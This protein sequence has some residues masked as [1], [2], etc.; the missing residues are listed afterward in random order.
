MSTSRHLL[1]QSFFNGSGYVYL[2]II[3]LISYPWFIRFSGASLFG[4]YLTIS[5]LIS[6][7]ITLDYG[8]SK[9][10][11]FH[12]ASLKPN[13]NVW[14]NRVSAGLSLSMIA[15]L[16][17]ASLYFLLTSNYIF[18]LNSFRSYA[19]E[20]TWLVL[21]PALI[22]FVYLQN[23]TLLSLFQSQQ[24]FAAYNLVLC[25][26]GT[27]NTILSVIIYGYTHSLTAVF[28]FQLC[29]QTLVLGGLFITFRL[30]HGQL[31]T[32]KVFPAIWYKLLKYGLKQ[33]VGVVASQIDFHASRI[34]IAAFLSSALVT[35][36]SLPQTLILKAAGG[37]SQLSLGL[38]PFSV[39]NQKGGQ[40]QVFRTIIFGELISLLLGLSAL[41]MIWLA[42]EP[43]LQI[44]LGNTE[45][46]TAVAP[47][48]RLLSLFLFLNIL[49]PIPSII[50]ESWGL[51]QIPSIS[52]VCT[53]SLD[54]IL[55]WILVPSFGVTGAAASLLI[56]SLITVPV[57]LLVFFYHLSRRR[58]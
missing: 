40:R 23:Q 25:F 53:V 52:A 12:L 43:L 34:V 36:F 33:F 11:V 24:Q 15:G 57:F 5:G 14:L 1:K 17:N 56:S 21:I 41:V 18:N 26:L 42:G 7:F 44:W 10:L 20:N 50:F 6:L 51:P 22:I 8:I 29:I 32:P 2:V 54:L 45:L 19:A 13:T 39:H 28:S 38:L 55:L 9:S 46:V 48:L 16:F 31:Y 35:V 4:F 37:M 58:G 30:I 47:I 27:A 3:S 49:T